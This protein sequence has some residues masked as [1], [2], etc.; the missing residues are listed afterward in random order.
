MV[1]RWKSWLWTIHTGASGRFGL[2]SRFN[3]IKEV[4]CLGR[5]NFLLGAQDLYYTLILG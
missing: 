5:S 3:S 4:N 1:G 2:L